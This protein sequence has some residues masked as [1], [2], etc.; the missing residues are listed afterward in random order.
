MKPGRTALVLLAAAV[1]L[2]VLLR[3]TGAGAPVWEARGRAH[4]QAGRLE[5]ATVALERAVRLAPRGDASLA[6]AGVHRRRGQDPEALA[7]LEAFTG[8]P[9]PAV[10][11]RTWHALSA[12]H[13]DAA[14][15]S[16]GEAALQ[17]RAR[18]AD[19]AIRAL[20][21][22]HGDPGARWNLHLARERDAG[23]PGQQDGSPADVELESRTA[24]SVR[25]ALAQVEARN[26]RE[27]LAAI[28]GELEASQPPRAAD[29]SQTKGPP[30]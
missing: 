29:D 16:P 7:V 28:L 11:A 4:A 20:R 8:S 21:I 5:P 25:A 1:V 13:L 22:R 24:R 6:L 15:H 18:A 14:G 2:E 23:T 3:A 10:R 26:L 19:A 12:L 27:S 9:D 17:A 30:W